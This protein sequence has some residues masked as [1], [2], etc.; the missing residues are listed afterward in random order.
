MLLR[1]GVEASIKARVRKAKGAVR[2]APFE[3]SNRGRPASDKWRQVA[4]RPR[5]ARRQDARRKSSRLRAL[6]AHTR[7]TSELRQL[8]Q[9]LGAVY[10]P[11][12]F[13]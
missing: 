1:G 5:R 7:A 10:K 8:L 13:V 2:T 12:N 11:D 4:R 3:F 9:F 6:K